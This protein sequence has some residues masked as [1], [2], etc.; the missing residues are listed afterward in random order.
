MY[1]QE[2]NT[3]HNL[4]KIIGLA[5]LMVML[6]LTLLF[7]KENSDPFGL[8]IPPTHTVDSIPNS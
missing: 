4:I 1:N 2:K 7:R 8:P 6:L 5:L 3:R